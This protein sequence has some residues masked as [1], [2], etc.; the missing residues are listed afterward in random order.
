MTVSDVFEN[1][2]G[3]NYNSLTADVRKL[4]RDGSYDEKA[5]AGAI[6][7]LCDRHIR[8]SQRE[9]MKRAVQYAFE[10][11]KAAGLVD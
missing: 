11:F 6:V 7:R 3:W 8:A 9:E 1:P 4:L 2:P 5:K 10:H